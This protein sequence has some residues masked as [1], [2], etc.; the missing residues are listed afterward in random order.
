MKVLVYRN[1]S[2]DLSGEWLASCINILSSED[3][4]YKVISDDD[5]KLSEKADAMFVLGGDGTILNLT[6]FATNNDIP[7]IGVNAGKLG[8]LTE[9]EQCEMSEAVSLLKKGELICDKRSNFLCKLNG[10]SYLSLNDIVLQRIKVEERGNNV[11]TLDV[12]IDNIK[13]E[14]F[15]GDGVIVSTPTGSTAYSLSAGGPIL[16]PGINVFSITP[17]AA[18]SFNQ[19]AIVY[20][21]DSLCK[22]SVKS[23]C[24]TGLFIDG[25]YAQQLKN[26]ETL[27]IERNSKP[28]VFLRRK[29]FNFYN[30]LNYKLKDRTAEV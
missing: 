4:D 21:A 3:I 2:K 23:E 28:T 22:I 11:T 26:G 12:E 13:V 5:L 8:F 18:H 25:I 6:E 10:K 27:L 19:R 14:K 30:R 15:I 16:A 29:G 17:I 9:F 7:I 20:S 24:A 1:L